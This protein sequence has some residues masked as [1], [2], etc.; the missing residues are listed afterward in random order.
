[1]M[2][3]MMMMMIIL[4][5]NHCMDSRK[6]LL[7]ILS[8]N[9]LGW[10]F[11]MSK[12]DEKMK[13]RILSIA[14]GEGIKWGENHQNHHNHHNHHYYYY[15]YYYY[16]QGIGGFVIGGTGT[17]VASVRSVNFMK[18]MSVSA[19]S[20]IPIMTGVFLFGLQYELTMNHARR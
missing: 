18:Y 13:E 17:Y 7:I 6:L 16:Y 8:S 2:M 9:N 4:F 10:I 19:K 14:C 12:V 1:M 11:T 15:Y 20:S 3:M 5:N